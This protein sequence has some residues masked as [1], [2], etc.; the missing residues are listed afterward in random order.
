METIR[1]IEDEK[2]DLVENAARVGGRALERLQTWTT[3]FEEVADV[4]GRGF[5][6]G[7]E[8]TNRDGRKPA[9]TIAELTLYNALERGLSFKTT[10]GTV[11]T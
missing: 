3:R 7:I 6:M 10:M 5:L 8:L 11:L 2:G 1:I 4:R 9:K